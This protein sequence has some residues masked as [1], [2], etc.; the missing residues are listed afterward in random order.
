MH[1]HTL[2]QLARQR[3]EEIRRTAASYRPHVGP[4]SPRNQFRHR[5][6]WTL[7]AVGLRVAGQSDDR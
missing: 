1:T 3:A 6:G 7:V 2:D 4:R 5:A